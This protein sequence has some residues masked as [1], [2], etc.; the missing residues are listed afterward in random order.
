[1]MKTRR[2]GF[3]VGGDV[4]EDPKKKINNYLIRHGFNPCRK[5]PLMPLMITMMKTR[6]GFSVGGDVAEDLN[7]KINN[8]LTSHIPAMLLPSELCC[9]ENSLWF[10]CRRRR[11]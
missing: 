8:Y 3:S 4:V 5:I 10:L 2:C 11:R 1:M 7:K 9:D 6:C